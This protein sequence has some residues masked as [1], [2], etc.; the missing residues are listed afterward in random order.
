MS[1]CLSDEIVLDGIIRKLI[2][3]A[4]RRAIIACARRGF[5]D[6]RNLLGI[7]AVAKELGARPR[8]VAAAFGFLPDAR[9]RR[10]YVD[11][12]ANQDECELALLP[13]DTAVAAAFALSLAVCPE[14]G[15]FVAE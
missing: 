1:P 4:A 5:G 11:V 8:V 9:N 3:P 6:A 2:S 15:A 10:R 12:L 13:K 7:L 14:G